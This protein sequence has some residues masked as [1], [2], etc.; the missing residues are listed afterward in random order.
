MKK[1]E[2]IL[3]LGSNVG[4]RREYLCS[5]VMA[6]AE[7]IDNIRVS[8]I[9]ESEALLPEGA[10]LT[11]NMPFYNMVI[12][13]I[14]N[15]LPQEFLAA[16]RQI[17]QNLG[18]NKIGHWCPRKIDIDILAMGDEVVDTP[19]LSIPHK[20]LLVRNFVLVPMA[21]IAPNWIHPVIGKTAKELA[22]SVSLSS[23]LLIKKPALVGIINI[24]PDSFSDGGIN[25]NPQ[26]ALA[27]IQRLV[28]DGADIIDIGAESTRPNATPISQGEEW[29]RLEPVLLTLK[30]LRSS[31]TQ[32]API[33]WASPRSARPRI[34]SISVDTRY[35]Q[36]ARK[37]LSLGIS[38]INDVSGFSSAE[39][40][41]AV[42]GSDCKLVV[43]HSLS[44]PTDKNIILPVDA[45][46]VEIVIEWAKARFLA[47]EKAG[48]SRD[49]IIFD[50]GIGFGKNAAQ[51]QAI[52]DGVSRFKELAVPI[53]IGHSRKSFLQNCHSECNEE[54]LHNNEKILRQA[55]DDID[56]ATIKASQF[57]AENGVDYLRV[58]NVKRHRLEVL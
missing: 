44:V 16:I 35:A 47:L 53:L 43:M 9:Y 24:T 51:S 15:L 19:D 8:S 28:E 40:V 30:N 56:D 21:E 33:N 49:R 26:V 5:A 25:F 13:G 39:M 27:N 14:T 50:A 58:H 7:Y 11:W 38:W 55:Q 17:E 6:L 46:P 31:A 29:E 23:L 12:A 52:I 37:A 20:E 41:E 2:V 3:G 36:T 57:L 48:I 18:R 4:N 42:R 22:K 45:D 54:S 1:C 32:A 10:P 34:P